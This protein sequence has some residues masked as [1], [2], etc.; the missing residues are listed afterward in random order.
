MVPFALMTHYSVT[1]LLCSGNFFTTRRLLSPYTDVLLVWDNVELEMGLVAEPNGLKEV[2]QVELE[3]LFGL[4]YE[5]HTPI[6]I[7]VTEFLRLYNFVGK[8]LRSF[9]RIRLMVQ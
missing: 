7:D 5:H 8:Q 2:N 1:I 9:L 4:A 6:C 3:L